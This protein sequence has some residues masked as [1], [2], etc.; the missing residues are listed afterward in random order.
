MFCLLGKC[1][2][3]GVSS[4]GHSFGV[5]ALWHRLCKIIA[6]Y[7]ITALL[8][9]EIDLRFFLDALGN[10]EHIEALGELYR[11]G[12]DYLATLACVVATEEICIELEHIK[13]HI[14]EGIERGIACAEIVH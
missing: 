2:L 12:D 13:R 8:G 14:L 9:K 5:F 6:L 10:G 1:G 7:H 4:T 3:F 11:L